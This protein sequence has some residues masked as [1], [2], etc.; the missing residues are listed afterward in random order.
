MLKLYFREQ[1]NFIFL[2]AAIIGI[3]WCSYL[4]LQWTEIVENGLVHSGM[5]DSFVPN[6]VGGQSS[7]ITITAILFRLGVNAEIVAVLSSALCVS[8]A[9]TAVT[10]VA[11]IFTP[12]KYIALIVPILL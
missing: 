4:D 3:I 7:Q 1:E 5:I 10:G 8:I 11:L 2:F 12:N 9:F 6:Y